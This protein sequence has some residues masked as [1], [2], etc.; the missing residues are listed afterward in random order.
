M[1]TLR[2]LTFD[3]YEKKEASAKYQHASNTRL[4]LKIGVDV[5]MCVDDRLR[6]TILE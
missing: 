2:C 6:W 4:M 1:E 5:L 3:Q